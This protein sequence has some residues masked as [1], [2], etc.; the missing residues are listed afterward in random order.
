M[1]DGVLVVDATVH[2]FNFGVDNHKEPWV[3]MIVEMLSHGGDRMYSALDTKKYD[4][5]PDEFRGSYKVQPAHLEE[6]LFA[7]SGTDI[8]CY[9][10]VPLYGVFHDGSSPVW[11]GRDIA[12]RLPHRMFVYFDLAPTLPNAM[13][14]IDEQAALPNTLGVK[15]Y[16]VDLVDGR[17]HHVQLNMDDVL[18]LIQRCKDRG[19][20]TIAIHK[21]VAFGGPLNRNFYDLNDMRPAIEAFPDLTF[22][23]VHGGYAFV[24][25]TVHLLQTY[26][27]VTINLE[28]NPM[29]A[30]MSAP[31]FADMMAG[32]LSTGKHEKIFFATGASAV[33]PTPII[34]GFRAFQMPQGRPRLTDEM[35][36][37]ILGMNFA[38]HH[39]WDVE[40][41]KKQIAADKYGLTRETYQRPWGAIHRA[42]E[43]GMV[44]E[45][46]RPPMPPGNAMMAVPGS[47]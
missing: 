38:R 28:T 23:I 46:P 3:T 37:G 1:I 12:S 43:E 33:H 35:K 44:F 10:G 45:V 4:L 22:E 34:E 15:F 41:M 47:A 5:T 25:E 26:D 16:P 2:G 42:K 24:D 31:R 27:N 11:I 21:A 39:G 14:W 13:E 19:I 20:K 8:A 17:V 32:L 29:M 18:P 6:A 7:E 30:F 9:H 36:E 40:A